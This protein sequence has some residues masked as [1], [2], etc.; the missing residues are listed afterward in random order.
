MRHRFEFGVVLLAV[1]ILGLVLA[2]R[3]QYVEERN[4]QIQVRLAVRLLD[5]AV[6]IRMAELLIANDA[7]TIERLRQENPFDW[8]SPQLQNYAG[9]RT[10]QQLQG[11]EDV[12]QG[13]W[14]FDTTRHEAVYT[15]L[16]GSHFSSR[17]G[18]RLIRYRVQ[19]IA[20]GRRLEGARIEVVEQY[21]WF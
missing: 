10:A 6:R 9:A 2:E 12:A 17:S 21:N 14:Y 1:S 19:V 13:R 11:R 3:L 16:N 7:Q 8:L 5:A 15:V 20:S 18:S 4:E